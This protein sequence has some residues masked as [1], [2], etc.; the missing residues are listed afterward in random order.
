M[1]KIKDLKSN[2]EVIFNLIDVLEL[3]SP[4]KKSKY[5]DTLLRLMKNT[6]NLKS[7]VDE[8]KA[9]FNSNFDFITN[10]D[11]NKFSD[12]QI[13]LMY[14]FVDSF[15]NSGDLQNFRKFCEYN[16]RGLIS[17]N[18]L[19]TYK[20]FDEVMNQLSLADLK[21]TSKDLENEIIKV[22]EDD[23]WLLVRPLTYLSSRKY[24][25][26]TKW[27]T[28]QES[29]PEYFM[30]YSKRGVLI[31]CI[32]KKTGYKVASFYSLDK[33]DPEFSFWNQKDSRIDSLDSELTDELRLVIQK[34]S[35]DPK[36]KTNRFLLSDEQRSKEDKLLGL[37]EFKSLSQID[38][39][40]EAVVPMRNRIENAIR[41]E[42]DVA[43]R[44]LED[45]DTMLMEREEERLYEDRENTVSE[46]PIDRMT[47]SSTASSGTNINYETE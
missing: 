31:Y 45:L 13:L 3:F 29:N 24:G 46:S 37:R 25:S 18:D 2:P 26:N 43:E 5:T 22:Y 12:I 28:T 44:N 1:S 36:A 33:N 41:R 47:W 8:I 30:K 42:N 32:N 6:K 35:K 16:E 27:C 39:A 4:D 17:Q 11:M 7:H 19:T 34:T 20:S 15:F 38:V 9:Y 40:E 14:R 23:E 10:E 21:V